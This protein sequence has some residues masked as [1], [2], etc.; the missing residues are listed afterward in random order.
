VTAGD[1]RVCS[2]CEGLEEANPHPLGEP[3][4][5]P[6]HGYCRCVTRAEDYGPGTGDVVAPYLT[7]T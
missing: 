6:A 1:E 7:S 2:I 4:A 3:L 5:C